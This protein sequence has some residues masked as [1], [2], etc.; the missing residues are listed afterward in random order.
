MFTNKNNLMEEQGKNILRT[1]KYK[2]T[3]S[4]SGNF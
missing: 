2:D 3:I 1:V 4:S